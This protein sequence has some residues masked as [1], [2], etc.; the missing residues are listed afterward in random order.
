MKICVIGAGYVGLTTAA[1][2]SHLDHDVHC[3][4]K[5]NKKINGL[6]QGEVPVFEPGLTEII[7]DNRKAH[8]LRFTSDYELALRNCEVIMIAVGT[9]PGIDGRP[10]LAA[11]DEV[12]G[13]LAQLIDSYK[14]I[15]TKS[16]VPPGTNERIESNLLERGIKEAFFDVVSNP[17]F[18]REGTAIEDTLHPNKIVVGVKNRKVIN[19]VRSLYRGI[20]APYIVTTYE[21]AEMIKYASNAFLATKISFV[22]ELS[23]ICDA[24]GVDIGD[25]EKGLGTDPRIGPHFLKAGLGYGGS[26]LP[27]D[28][29]ALEQAALKKQVIPKLLYAV[30]AVNESQSDLYVNKLKR[31]L[32]GLS[33]KQVTVWG[34]TFKANTDDI[35]FSQA[36]RLIE[37]LKEENCKI[38]TYDPQA[39]K[40]DIGATRF[41]DLYEALNGSEALVIA[42][43][44]DEFKRADW[45]KVKSRLHGNIILDGRNCLDG[46]TVRSYGLHYTGVARR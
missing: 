19:T 44:W 34:L 23:R 16:T 45:Q 41:E 17:E 46:E 24:Y 35:R 30:K 21:G 15:L 9:P 32:S 36:H 26:C 7:R 6:N 4:D 37:R 8:R 10:N 12:T 5:D 28:L 22:N 20:D 3:L 42:T 11:I 18:L 13:M 29:D 38:H 1:V 27:K 40:V 14:L 33:G 43:D 2:L 25:V 39:T 31:E